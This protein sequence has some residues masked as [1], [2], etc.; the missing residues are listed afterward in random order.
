MVRVALA[1]IVGVFVLVGSV[2]AQYPEPNELQLAKEA[3][4]QAARTLE[5][6]MTAAQRL[7]EAGKT[8][9]A[10]A[11]QEQALR[12]YDV[13]A[14]QL[15]EQIRAMRAEVVPLKSCVLPDET[16]H[17]VD[18]TVTFQGQTLRCVIVLDRDL[19]PSDVAWS[20][21]SARE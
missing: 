20:P 15:N 19:R 1:A 13:A 5:A 7:R 6:E 17:P 11:A 18:A 12:R 8:D 4:R 10:S 16:T 2:S 14:R 3:K 21:S 9:L